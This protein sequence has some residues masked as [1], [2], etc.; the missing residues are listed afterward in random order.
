MN[1]ETTNRIRF[2]LEDVLPPFLR[3]SGVFRWAAKRVWGD[4]ISQ[5]AKFRERAPFLSAEEYAELYR[6]HPRVHEGTDNSAAC[7]A[8]IVGSIEGG[9]VCD[10]GCGT[11][12]L[13]SRIQ[14]AH[15]NLARL[16]GV[17]FVIDDASSLPRIEYVAAKVE[18]LP[19]ADG[20]FDTVICTHVIEHILDYRQAI[21]ELRRI[22]KRQLIIVVPREREYRYTFNPHFNFFP[23][24]HSFLRAVHPVP[25]TFVCEDIG[26]DIFY[27]ED[28]QAA[29]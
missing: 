26:R 11:G 7:I 2:V 6:N 14:S 16:V 23:Y 24:T 25:P 29:N 5:L 12:A 4:H 18:R 1:R 21:A 27:M 10:V 19:F 3:D 9:S 8:R 13:L 17:D 22:A 28:R 20:E 15:P